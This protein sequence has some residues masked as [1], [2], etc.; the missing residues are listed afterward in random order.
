MDLLQ[1]QIDLAKEALLKEKTVLQESI[2]ALQK[3]LTEAYK[4]L[5]TMWDTGLGKVVVQLD[6]VLGR[7]DLLVGYG[8]ALPG[9]IEKES[10]ALQGGILT[11][12]QL[13]TSVD[14]TLKSIHGILNAPTATATATVNVP[15]SPQAPVDYTAGPTEAEEYVRDLQME[16]LILEVRRL[17]TEFDANMRQSLGYARRSTDV[18]VRWDGDGL[19]PDNED[20]LRQIAYNTRP[21]NESPCT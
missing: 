16:E 21:R 19:P 2:E 11:S 4:K 10:I 13:L 8:L 5:Q 7:M 15:E 3:E 20:Y 9:Q 6:G 17:R 12:N 14:A 1:E 18:L